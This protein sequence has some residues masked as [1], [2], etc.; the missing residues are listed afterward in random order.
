MILIICINFLLNS[1]KLIIKYKKKIDD[2][3]QNTILFTENEISN[4]THHNTTI[5]PYGY[6][7]CTK[8]LYG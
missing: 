2:M 4:Y 7:Y 8:I 3:S 6:R 5:Y 1:Q